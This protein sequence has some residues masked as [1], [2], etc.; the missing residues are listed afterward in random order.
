MRRKEIPA[1]QEP[2]NVAELLPIEEKILLTESFDDLFLPVNHPP[3][4][5]D[6]VPLL[7]DQLFLDMENLPVIDLLHAL[8]RRKKARQ[9][10]TRRASETLRTNVL[11]VP[12]C[13]PPVQVVQS[14][15]GR[16]SGVKFPTFPGS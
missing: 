7:P 15:M 14:P 1:E 13:Q 11:S 5:F 8:R 3:L 10:I 12:Y 6:F 16:T 4:R 9:R 2:G